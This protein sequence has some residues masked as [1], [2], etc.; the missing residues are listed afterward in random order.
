M[1]LLDTCV[2]SELVKP[3]PDEK[4][5]RWVDSVDERSLFLSVL[6]LGELEKGISKLPESP[7]KTSLKEWLEQDM[8]ERFA[9]RILPV[10]AAV[11]MAWGKIQGEGE[12]VGT[13]LPVIDS[14]LAA[15]AEIHR[16]T[17][18]TRNVTDFSR[19]GANVFNPW[20]A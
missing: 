13:K 7:R 12:K 17:L 15:T 8:A 11:A 20:D 19:C 9:G 4:V 10:D 18:A 16:L 6:T 3:R 2:I 1:F 5:V 14:L